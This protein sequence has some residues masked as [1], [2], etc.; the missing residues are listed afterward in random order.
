LL[1]YRGR[2]EIIS[3]ILGVANGGSSSAKIMYKVVL[4]YAQAKG[5][6]ALLIENGLVEFNENELKFVTTDK[7]HKFLKLYAELGDLRP[8]NEIRELPYI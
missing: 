1:K 5:Y 8:R 3:Q 2:T 4:S 6:L 7:G